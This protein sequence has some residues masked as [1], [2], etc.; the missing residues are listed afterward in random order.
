MTG[1]QKV[2]GSSPPGSTTPEFELLQKNVN[3]AHEVQTE[4]F[5]SLLEELRKQLLEASIYFDIWEQTW[6]TPQVVDVINRYKGFFQPTRRAFLDQ[7]SIKICNVTGNDRRLPSFYKVFKML[8][9]NPSLAPHVN[10]RLLRKRLKQHS[11]ILAA[12]D[13]YR[14]TKA[15]HWDTTNNQVAERKPVLFG[16]SK[17]MLKDL[18]NIFNEICGAATDRTWSFKPLEHKDT[19]SLLS[20]L[21]ELHQ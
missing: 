13:S 20:H 14:D 19:K 1:S 17:R 16:N 5:T 8:D 11:I 15:A 6:P 7:F 21:N 12:I 9:I 2:G 4:E 3:I 18:Q 10:T